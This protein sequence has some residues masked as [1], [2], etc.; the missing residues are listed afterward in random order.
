MMALYQNLNIKGE[1]EKW[2][3]L[4]TPVFRKV[5]TKYSVTLLCLGLADLYTFDMVTEKKNELHLK[6]FEY[7]I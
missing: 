1:A 6:L 7:V 4:P 2:E 3:A 5:S